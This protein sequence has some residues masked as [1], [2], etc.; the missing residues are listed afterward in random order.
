MV[1][2]RV[3]ALPRI[4]NHR[5]DRRKEHKE[6]EFKIQGLLMEVPSPL[7]F[8]PKD[9]CQPL[10]RH[11][12]ENTI[13]QGPGC[14]DHGSNGLRVRK[15]LSHRVAIA[16]IADYHLSGCTQTSKFFDQVTRARRLG[17]AP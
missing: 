8:R 9:V 12:L 1:R 16:H 4:T 2:R 15:E 5:S 14:V 11:V 6:I 13:V 17:A 3:I 10:R 7:H